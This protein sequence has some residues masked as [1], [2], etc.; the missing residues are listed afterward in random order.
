MISRFQRYVLDT[1]WD[2]WEDYRAE[3]EARKCTRAKKLV[4][5]LAERVVR[6]D[7]AFE[8]LLPKLVSSSAETGALFAFG[9]ALGNADKE[10][11]CLLPLLSTKSNSINSQ[12]LGGYLAGLKERD[13]NKWSEVLLG[14][15]VNEETANRGADLV[16]C[17]GFDDQVLGACIDAFEAV[18]G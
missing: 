14:L 7:E 15:L 16:R 1:T 8:G 12:C 6:N 10:N 4:R 3:D 9:Q 17:S 5:T 11:K 18:D 2:E 13:P